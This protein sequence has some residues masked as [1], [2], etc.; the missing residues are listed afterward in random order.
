MQIQHLLVASSDYITEDP[1][2]TYEC[3]ILLG[4][5]ISSHCESVIDVALTGGV[6]TPFN[7]P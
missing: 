4:D 6:E 2:E 3:V 7:P 1:V 5:T